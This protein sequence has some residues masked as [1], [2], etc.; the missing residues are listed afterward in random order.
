MIKLS[1]FLPDVNAVNW[2]D[3]ESIKE[4]AIQVSLSIEE[5][6]RKG[7]SIQTEIMSSAP[8]AVTQFETEGEDIRVDTGVA[9]STYTLLNGSIRYHTET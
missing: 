2:N 1:Q 7:K 9:R 5:L 4:W 6:A 3:P 8:T